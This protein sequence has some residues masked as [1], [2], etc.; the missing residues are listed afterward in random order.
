MS[1][2][3]TG[4]AAGVAQTTHTA[5]QTARTS[6]A[7]ARQRADASQAERESFQLH[8]S[9]AGETRDADEQLPDKPPPFYERL[10]RG[11]TAEGD[12][13][14][15]PESDTPDPA[16]LHLYDPTHPGQPAPLY[17]HLDVKA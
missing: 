13:A 7:K 11:D 12:T 9:S 6:D 10:W 1:V 3:G 4:I 15:E 16:Q 8:L 2:L 17:R 5:Q 14:Q